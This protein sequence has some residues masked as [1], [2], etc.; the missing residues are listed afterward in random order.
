MCI[1]DRSYYV[2]FGFLDKGGWAEVAKDKNYNYKRYNVLMKADF[3]INDWLTMDEQ[4]TWSAEH[5]DQPHF[6]NWDVNINT[7]ARVNPN[8]TVTFPDLPY[9]LEPGDH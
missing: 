2:S 5:N 8:T 9:Y 3:K 7:V 1:R 6:Y 4:I